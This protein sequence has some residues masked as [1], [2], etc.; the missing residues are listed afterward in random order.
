MD[1]NKQPSSSFFS[2]FKHSQ[3]GQSGTSK[4]DS[5]PSTSATS[6]GGPIDQCQDSASLSVEP[7]SKRPSVAKKPK[8]MDEEEKLI[9]WLDRFS[10]AKL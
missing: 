6:E 10:V 4:E 2:F 5:I 7:S 8:L 3:R 1:K 9:K